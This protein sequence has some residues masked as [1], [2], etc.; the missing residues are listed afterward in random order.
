M[1]F[2]ASHANNK[3]HRYERETTKFLILRRYLIFLFS[4]SHPNKDSV[5]ICVWKRKFSFCFFFFRSHTPNKKPHLKMGV[6]TIFMLMPDFSLWS[7]FWPESLWLW[8]P[9]SFRKT[10]TK[11]RWTIVTLIKKQDCVA[12]NSPNYANGIIICIKSPGMLHL[13]FDTSVYGREVFAIY[14]PFRVVIS[15]LL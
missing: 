1:L 2:S 3:P 5:N 9:L 6:R 14:L 12:Q 10:R 7:P 13:A 4:A 8:S 15:F 11:P